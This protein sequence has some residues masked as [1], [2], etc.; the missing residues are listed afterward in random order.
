[1][2]NIPGFDLMATQLENGRQVANKGQTGEL[3]PKQAL[4]HLMGIA[5]YVTEISRQMLI[6]VEEGRL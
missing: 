3:V 2:T 4:Y 1:M 5:A 6:D